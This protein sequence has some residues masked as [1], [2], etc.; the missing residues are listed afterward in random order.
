M[1]FVKEATTLKF[2]RFNRAGEQLIGIPLDDL[3]GKTDYDFFPKHE[4]DLFTAMDREVL[5]QRQVI[6]IPE[7][8]RIEHNI[9]MSWWRPEPSSCFRRPPNLARVVSNNQQS[10]SLCLT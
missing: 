6:D 8:S 5:R 9:A 7:Y 4:A 3:R 1:I 10:A 2:V